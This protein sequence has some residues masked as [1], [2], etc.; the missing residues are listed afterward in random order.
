MHPQISR[1]EKI[2]L[3]YQLY[4][5]PMYRIA[6][7]ILHHTEQTEDA[8][9]EAFCYIIRHLDKFEEPESAKTKQYMIRLI[10]SKAIDQYR[11]NAVENN[12]QTPW[13]DRVLQVPESTDTLEQAMLYTEQQAMLEDMLQTL[14]E[15][16]A[17][18]VL[19]RC[20]EGLSFREIAAR[21]SMKESTARKRFERAR[22]TMM[23]SK[24]VTSYEQLFSV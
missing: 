19:L 3:L 8:V 13:D 14:N 7:A 4:E 6:Y 24:G 11:K 20:A 17:R 9:S 18:I 10:R 23:R 21:V 16:D 1:K 5:K 2:C 12:R 15:T 22:K